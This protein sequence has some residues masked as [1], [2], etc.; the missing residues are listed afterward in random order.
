MAGGLTVSRRD[1]AG[2]AGWERPGPLREAASGGSRVARHHG[3]GGPVGAEF[4]WSCAGAEWAQ[5]PAFAG[6]YE[7]FGMARIRA[8][9]APMRAEKMRRC[10][11]G[12]VIAR[13]VRAPCASTGSAG[14]IALLRRCV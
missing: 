4:L 9:G 2:L 7:F 11:I 8:G 5:R 13:R 10:A 14:A 1:A 3:A 6:V 12:G